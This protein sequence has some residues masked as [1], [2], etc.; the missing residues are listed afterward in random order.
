MRKWLFCLLGICL[1]VFVFGD[2][3]EFE[4]FWNETLRAYELY[5][6]GKYMI[7]EDITQVNHV[8]QAAS[9]AKLAGAPHSM[10]VALLFHDIGQVIKD[11]N[12]GH[13]EILH[14]NHAEIGAKW[15]EQKGFHKD[16]VDFVYY[17]ALAKVV[18]C[19]LEPGYFDH[20]SL[21]S[22]ISYAYQKEKYDQN[23]DVVLVFMNHPLYQ[24]YLAARKCDDMAKKSSL[25]IENGNLPGFAT[26]RDLV[27]S[28]YNKKEEIWSEDWI[29]VVNRWYSG[30]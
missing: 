20:L 16:I 28:V 30:R 13:M 12:I 8:L 3:N 25:S 2:Q 22:R 23:Q 26:Y 19:D 27:M 1:S 10:V 9:I 15:L 18:L 11:E 21:A 17:H 14:S 29:E 6:N 5:G 4:E 24:Q 7:Q